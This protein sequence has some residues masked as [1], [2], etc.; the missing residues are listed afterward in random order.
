[1]DYP[2]TS[3]GRQLVHGRPHSLS[4]GRA[5]AMR[6]E[7]LA[8]VGLYDALIVGVGD[9]AVVQAALGRS[10]AFVDEYELSS[11]RS[12]HYLE[13]AERFHRIV[14]G[15][16]GMVEGDIYHLWHGTLENRQYDSRQ[17]ILRR[18]DFDPYLDIALDENGCWRWNSDKPDLH[19]EVKAYFRERRDDSL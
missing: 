3:S 13:W 19:E 9:Y 4:P 8:Q 12:R 17:E 7:D 15:N 6:R 14:D 11:V 16:L 18:F 10:Q 2:R 1:M 5:W